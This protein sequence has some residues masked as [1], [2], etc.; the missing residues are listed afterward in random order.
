MS[1]KRLVSLMMNLRSPSDK[2]SITKLNPN[3]HSISI[4]GGNPRCSVV[5]D[6]LLVKSN[7]GACNKYSMEVALN[8]KKL[9]T[10]IG[11]MEKGKSFEYMRN[12]DIGEIFVSFGGAG[13][14]HPQEVT[15]KRY[16]EGDTVTVA[17]DFNKP[18]E[19]RV[20]YSVNNEIVGVAPWL[21]DQAYFAI[22]VDKAG[23][24]EL[25]VKFKEE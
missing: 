18:H 10:A 6:N 3:E 19:E 11:L 1:A 24:A 5:A 2:I 17:V 23:I 15:A 16:G 20:E 8:T 7:D 25:N 14:I 13:L 21:Y 4:N 9:K 12:D 22:S